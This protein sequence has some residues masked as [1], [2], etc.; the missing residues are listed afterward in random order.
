MIYI[1]SDKERKLPHHFDCSCA[2]FGSIE[3]ARDF[4]LTSYEEIEIGKFD[5]LIKSRLFV[6]STEFMQLVFSRIGKFDVRLPRNSNRE[7]EIITLQEA[8]D[9]VRN[10]EKLFIKPTKIKL[11]TG[12]VLD[13]SI[14]SELRGV[15]LDTEV[16][17]Y[18]PFTKRLES[19]W[20]IYIHN[21][22]IVDSRNY[23]GDFKINPDYNFIENI[24]RENKDFP[25]AYTIDVGQFSDGENVVIEFNDMWAIGNYGMPNDLY[26]RLLSDRYFEIV[27]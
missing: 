5:S 23:S 13:G 15:P 11:F 20:R 26:L 12:L 8:H 19:E 16:L 21:S 3:S 1:Q 9:R 14:Y 7:S 22:K 10:G 24:I 17:A 18:K 25:V 2:M 4:R 27:R 6:G